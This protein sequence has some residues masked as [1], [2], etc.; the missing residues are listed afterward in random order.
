MGGVP[1]TVKT[2]ALALLACAVFGVSCADGDAA[3]PAQRH[4]GPG[5][6]T[7]RGPVGQAGQGGASGDAPGKATS[8]APSQQPLDGAAASPGDA[9]PGDGE[10]DGAGGAPPSCDDQSGAVCGGNMSP[11]GDPAMRYFCANGVLI[12]QARCPG[13]CQVKSN[14]CGMGTGTGDGMDDA[15]LG[16]TL[17]CR[18]CLADDCQALLGACNADP[19]CAAHLDCKESCTI[20][21]DCLDTCAATFPKHALMDE[22]NACALRTECSPA[23]ARN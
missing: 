11:I 18:A 19:W 9:P 4:S 6:V 12:A 23:C 21:D 16:V 14:A 10:G 1:Q 20:D 2:L 8:G 15:P 22:L 3:A 5:H 17:H 7:S 13:V